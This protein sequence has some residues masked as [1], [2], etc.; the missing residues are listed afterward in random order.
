MVKRKGGDSEEGCDSEEGGEG[1]EFSGSN[2]FV[3]FGDSEEG[4]DSEEGGDEETAK[5][6]LTTRKVT[7][8]KTGLV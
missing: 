8:N 1:G 7:A 5:K 3:S 2:C 4:C 6:V